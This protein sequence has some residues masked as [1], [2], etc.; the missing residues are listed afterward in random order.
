[1]IEDHHV[2]RY[3]VDPADEAPEPVRAW[4]LVQ[5][6]T[7]RPLRIE[8]ERHLGGKWVTRG[9]VEFRFPDALPERIFEPQTLAEEDWPERD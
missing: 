9:T 4:I 3:L 6:D 5:A 7:D 1:M 2:E 8:M